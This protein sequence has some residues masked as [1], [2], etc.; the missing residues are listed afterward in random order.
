MANFSF[1]AEKSVRKG[2]TA[3]LLSLLFT[4]AALPAAAQV[5]IRADVTDVGRLWLG[6]VAPPVCPGGGA[7]FRDRVERRVAERIVAD[8]C[9]MLGQQS[10]S[11]DADEAV[12]RPYGLHL[13]PSP[14]QQREA[15]EAWMR[16]HEPVGDVIAAFKVSARGRVGDGK[17]LS[18][19]GNRW[20]ELVIACLDEELLW[21]PARRL[22]G[23]VR[24]PEPARYTVVVRGERLCELAG[25]RIGSDG[26]DR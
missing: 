3:V 14:Q 11:P 26:A 15:V 23:G 6:T 20:G 21:I 13:A 16:A 5:P 18:A 1:A 9:R 2:R 4:G 19:P 22:R 7:G 24:R 17:I 12:V 10:G 25:K 8:A